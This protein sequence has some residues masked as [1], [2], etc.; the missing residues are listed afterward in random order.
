MESTIFVPK[1][2]S[3]SR[4]VMWVKQT[5]VRSRL[6][7]HIERCFFKTKEAPDKVSRNVM[8]YSEFVGELSEELESLM[9]SEELAYYLRTLFSQGVKIKDRLLF[10][11]HPSNLA[12]VSGFHGKFSE[13]LESRI[14]DPTSMVSYAENVGPL[15]EHLERIIFSDS[16]AVVRYIKVLRKHELEVPERV[17]RSLMG[18]DDHFINL[19]HHIGRLPSY[20]EETISDPNIALNYARYVVRGR[21]PEKVE[22]VFLNAPSLA[23][24]YAFEVIRGFSSV[25][26]PEVIHNALIMHSSAGSCR[27]EIQ[28][29]FSELERLSEKSSS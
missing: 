11:L 10:R 3:T 28:R 1:F 2:R 15:P 22:E 7:A 26:L 18:K 6:P 19:S 17:F 23:V 20:L 8:F 21:L 5:K 27:G 25:Q 12:W 24:R 4:L 9:F 29:Y 14:T 13:E 16:D